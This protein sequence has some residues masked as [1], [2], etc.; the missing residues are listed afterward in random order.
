VAANGITA[1]SFATDSI[2]SSKISPDVAS[3]IADQVWNETL[4]EHVVSGSTGAGLTAA[5]AA[6]DPWSTAVPGAYGAGTAG[7]LIGSHINAPIG[8]VDT[9]V[10]AIKAKTDNLPASPAAV[11]SNMGLAAATIDA[12]HDEVVEGS[13]T[14]RELMRGV[15][16]A[17]FGVVSGANGGASTITFSDLASSKTR[18][19]SE[20]DGSGNRISITLDLTE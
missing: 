1:S 17:L 16:S 3:E 15:A 8:T 4:S 12:I 6:G 9:V 11:G 5:G 2:T 13:T 20:V 19:T 7:Y 14:F 10:D 18:I